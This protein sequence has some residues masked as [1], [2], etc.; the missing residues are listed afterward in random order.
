MRILP[1]LT[2]ATLALA[3]AACGSDDG[4][5][6]IDAST[7]DSPPGA[8]DAA[9]DAPAATDPLGRACTG[10][11]QGTCPAG[12]DCL[13]LTGGSGSWCSKV[14]TGNMDTSCANG[15][16]G[17]GF[18]ACLITVHPQNPPPN[19]PGVPHCLIICEDVPGTPTVCPG[20]DAQCN[21]MC[22]TPLMCTAELKNTAGMVLA[23]GCQ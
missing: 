9:V 7:I 20:G 13:S 17:S 16:T 1:S 10:T 4:G 12:Y 8:I 18:P 3:L 15:Y 11:G 19:D 2:L 22:P 23:R 21:R 14:C 6:A 5:A